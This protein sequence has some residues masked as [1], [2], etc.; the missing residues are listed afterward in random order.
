V[1][2]A[3]DYRDFKGKKSSHWVTY[4]SIDGKM[5]WA[6]CWI[7]KELRNFRGR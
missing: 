2:F 7:S 4:R 3:I 6:Y 5:L 1:A